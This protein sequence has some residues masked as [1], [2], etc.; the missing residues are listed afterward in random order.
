MELSEGSHDEGDQIQIQAA[1]ATID[2]HNGKQNANL[3][4]WNSRITN[5]GCI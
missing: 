1:A 4:T 5:L 2:G 3:S